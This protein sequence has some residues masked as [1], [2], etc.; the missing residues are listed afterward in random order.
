MIRS[1]NAF[2]NCIKFMIYD[3]PDDFIEELF[4]SRLNWYQIGLETSMIGSDFI[5]H[6]VHFFYYKCHEIYLNHDGS[7]IDSPNWVKSKK[8]TINLI[9]KK[10]GKC[11]QCFITVALNQEEIGTRPERFYITFVNKHNRKGINYPSAKDDWKKFEKNNVTIAP[12]VLYAKNE[13]MYPIFFFLNITQIV[14]KA[15]LS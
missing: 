14:K 5:F 12:N 7:Y 4:E 2:K 6:C 8:A 3:N 10:Y 13:K 1:C 11:F 9:N 15:S